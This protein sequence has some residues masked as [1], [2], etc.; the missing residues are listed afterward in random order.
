MKRGNGAEVRLKHAV[1]CAV[2]VTVV[3]YPALVLPVLVATLV[4]YCIVIAVG[5]DTGG[6]VLIRFS[7]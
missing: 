6:V 4:T 5:A 3:A 1:T 7:C 2:Y